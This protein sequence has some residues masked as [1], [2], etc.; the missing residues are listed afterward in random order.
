MVRP[1]LTVRDRRR[2]TEAALEPPGAPTSAHDQQL[3]A[4]PVRYTGHVDVRTT[5]PL[6][7]SAW[8]GSTNLGDELILSALLRKL[9]SH[10]A[11]AHV[12][13]VDPPGTTAEHGAS[14]SSAS[15]LAIRGRGRPR[16]VLLGGGGLLQDETSP[17]NLPFHLGRTSMAAARGP[18]AGVGLGVGPLSGRGGRVLVRRSL[19]RAVATSV[20]DEPSRSLLRSIG[21][22][23]VLAADLALSLP[24]PQVTVEGRVGVSLRPWTGGR[25]VLP[26]ALRRRR[27][28]PVTA[29]WFVPSMAASLDEIA[30]RTGLAIHF[31]ALQGDRDDAV[32]RAVAGA[33][34]TPSTS[35]VPTAS[36]VVEEVAS[37]EVV[38]AMRYHA[39][40]AAVLGGRPAVLIGYSPKV[41]SL[42]REVPGGMLGTAWDETSLAELPATLGRVL[43]GTAAVLAARELLRV[44]EARN[45]VVIEELL[46][47]ARNI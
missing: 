5:A 38:V 12:L 16:A 33:M 19:G 40:I 35:S 28:S 21:V 25:H 41:P 42:A 46:A 6:V 27:P 7:V 20:R 13:S 31:V 10:G 22:E 1:P 14:A 39:G 47:A 15:H 18:V 26:V 3:G 9:R 45:D 8:A 43:G 30:G 37:C 4:A 23:S 44:R 17:F 11:D 24:L 32:H 29:P 34:R 2:H 36:T